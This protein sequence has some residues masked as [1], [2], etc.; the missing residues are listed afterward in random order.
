MYKG[1]PPEGASALP[2]AAAN[3]PPTHTHA[4]TRYPPPKAV[5]RP[6]AGG[7]PPPKA[8]RHGRLRRGIPRPPTRTHTHAHTRAY[9]PSTNAE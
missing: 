7:D 3:T 6:P 4:H 8:V 5:M 9:A 1:I 2:P